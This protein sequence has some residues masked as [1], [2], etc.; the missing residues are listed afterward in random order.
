MKARSTLFI[1][2]LALLPF[3]AS[4]FDDALVAA[5]RKEGKVVFY[6]SAAIEATQK[7]C[8]GFER[9]YSGVKCEFYRATALPCFN[10]HRNGIEEHQGRRDPRFIGAW[11]PQC[12][13]Q[14]WLVK[15]NR[16]KAQSIC[17]SSRTRKAISSPP[18]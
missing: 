15:Y 18:A 2:L 13:R 4:A 16:L 7:I 14:G 17:R 11:I 6:S 12:P 3:A 8:Q 10:Q 5:A 1:S 9:T